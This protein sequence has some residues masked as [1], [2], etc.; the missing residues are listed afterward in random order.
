LANSKNIILKTISEL[1]ADLVRMHEVADKYQKINEYGTHQSMLGVDK[2]NN[3][4]SKHSTK[5]LNI[6][7][8]VSKFQEEIEAVAN[9]FAANLGLRE[10]A[11]RNTVSEGLDEIQRAVRNSANQ[12]APY[13]STEDISR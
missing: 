2:L 10:S 1:K 6:N 7:N 3:A 4:L 9:A 5:L 12:L 13:Q 8:T 11:T